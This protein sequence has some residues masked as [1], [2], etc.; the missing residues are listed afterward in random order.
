[1]SPVPRFD[2]TF[3]NIVGLVGVGL[4]LYGYVRLQ[5]QRDYAKRIEYSLLNLISCVLIILSLLHEWNLPSFIS[6]LLWGVMSA[7]GVWRCLK[8]RRREKEGPEP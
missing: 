3:H 2:L 4:A 5:L 8:Y 1:M 6:N 7:Y